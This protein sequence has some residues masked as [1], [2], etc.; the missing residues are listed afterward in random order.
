MMKNFRDPVIFSTW[1]SLEV[2]NDTQALSK[3]A[4]H[5]RAADRQTDSE[6]HV[7]SPFPFKKENKTETQ[8][9]AQ[10][11]THTHIPTQ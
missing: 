8:A 10:I 2:L 1:D 6:L 11:H 7:K 4:G 9:H 3:A 5:Q